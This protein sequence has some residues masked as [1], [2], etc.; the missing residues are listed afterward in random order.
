MVPEQVRDCHFCSYSKRVFLVFFFFSCPCRIV[1]SSQFC[2]ALFGSLALTSMR[3]FNLVLAFLILRMEI[4]W[5]SWEIFEDI[6]DWCHQTLH[7][8]DPCC[9][10][11][12]HASLL[13]SSYRRCTWLWRVLWRTLFAALITVLYMIHIC[14]DTKYTVIVCRDM[15]WIKCHHQS[16]CVQKGMPMGHQLVT[17]LHHLH[18]NGNERQTISRTLWMSH[19]QL[20]YLPRF[21]TYHVHTQHSD[22]QLLLWE[23]LGDLFL[24][25]VPSTHMPQSW[26]L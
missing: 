23:Q 1:L 16:K 25:I 4:P 21:Q 5:F 15:L 8:K 10:V 11:C 26:F 17:F 7:W 13:E 6:L 18:Q 2:K 12:A 3:T 22:F 14:V 19:L 24:L 20:S 9:L